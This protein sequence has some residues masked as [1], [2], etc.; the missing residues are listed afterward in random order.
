[1]A[2]NTTN[3][4]A[5]SMPSTESSHWSLKGKPI[6]VTGASGFLGSHLCLRLVDQG[7]EVHAVSRSARHNSDGG[8]RWWQAEL[9]DVSSVR[10]VMAATKPAVIY[11]L[12]GLVTA[13]AGLDLVLPTL[14]TLLV[15]TVNVLTV[16]AEQQCE[17]LVLA[18]SL[19][20]PIHDA[21]ESI[22]GS[23]YAA[24]K[25]ASSAYGRMFYKL[26]GLPVT[27]LRIFMTYGPGQPLSKVIPYATLSLLRQEAPKLSSGRWQGDWIYIDDVVDGLIATASSS[28]IAGTTI[29]LGSGQLVS[30]REIVEHLVELTGARVAPQFSAIPDRPAEH[31]RVADLAHARKMLGWSPR[32]SLREGLRRTVDWYRQPSD[33]RTAAE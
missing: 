28:E 25:W 14:H 8:V 19:Q 1:M 18:G 4:K 30:T 16:A 3:T 10:H 22:P 23:P 33:S 27:N 12:S 24:A 2:L 17:R 11:H 7:A 5:I 26:Y 32:I 20:E 6:L 9:A 29:D 13:A 31:I 15:S 21:P